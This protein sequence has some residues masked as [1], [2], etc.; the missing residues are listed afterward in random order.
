MSLSKI[1]LK[2]AVYMRA[3]TGGAVSLFSVKLVKDN[4]ISVHAIGE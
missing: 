3:K 2:M 1:A 4:H